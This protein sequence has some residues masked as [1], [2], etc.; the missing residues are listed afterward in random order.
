MIILTYNNVLIKIIVH[1]MNN[2]SLRSNIMMFVYKIVHIINL[3]HQ[4]IKLIIVFYLM[5][6]IHLYGN[7]LM[8]INNV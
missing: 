3:L 8:V 2:K 6:V 4:V 1:H 5:S 7:M